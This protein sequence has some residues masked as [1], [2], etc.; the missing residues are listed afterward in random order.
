[1]KVVKDFTEYQI[2]GASKG[3]KIESW[4]GIILRR[5]D[6]EIIW[7]DDNFKKY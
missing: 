6:P 1:M 7:E 3:E 4:N 2:L 5:P